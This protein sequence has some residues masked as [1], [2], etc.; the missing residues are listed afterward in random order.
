MVKDF[1]PYRFKINPYDPLVENTIINEK[2][3]TVVWQVDDLNVS[4]VDIFEV[5]K[6]SGYMS[7]IYGGI[8]LHRIKLH[9]NLGIDLDYRKQVTLKVFMIK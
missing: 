3:M 8:T 5:T 2:L 7:S 4:H 9:D 6:F 1:D